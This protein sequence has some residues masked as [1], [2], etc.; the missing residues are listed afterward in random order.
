MPEDLPAGVRLLAYQ[1][2]I[3]PETSRAH[4]QFYIAM[5]KKV[6]ATAIMTALG[7]TKGKQWRAFPCKGTEEQNLIYCSKKASRCA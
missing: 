2:E 7:L 4:W 5:L 1:P 6:K 3:A